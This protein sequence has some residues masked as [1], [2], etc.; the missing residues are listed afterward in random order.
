MKLKKYLIEKKAE[1]T[2]DEFKD[3]FIKQLN[4]WDT[5]LSKLTKAYNSMK[6]PDKMDFYERKPEGGY[7]LKKGYQNMPEYKNFLYL[8]QA[9]ATFQ[10]NF[11]TWVYS[12]VLD[13]RYVEKETLGQD[14]V[15]KTA[16]SF[17][18]DLSIYSL[19]PDEYDYEIE[20]HIPAPW[21]LTPT[22][23]KKRIT[24]YQNRWRKFKEAFQFLVQYGAER[25]EKIAP[26][27]QIQISGV[28]ILIKN[29]KK[30]NDKDVKTFISVVKKVVP[31]IKK[32][33]MGKVLRDFSMELNFNV[34]TTQMYSKYGDLV[35]G[36]YNP[37]KDELYIFP[38]GIRDKM[39]DNTLIHEL[40]HRYW[41]K[42]IPPK[43]KQAWED[44]INAQMIKVEKEHIEKFFKEF[45]GE[46]G[47]PYRRE[48]E[49][50]I[51]KKISDP[52]LQVIFEYLAD[53]TPLFDAKGRDKKTVYKEW[54]IKRHVGQQV[55]LEM[56]SDYGRTNPI[57]AFA[58]AFKIWVGGSK[59]KLGEW[60]RAFF[61]EIV[62]TGGATIKEENL[63]EKYLG[64]GRGSYLDNKKMP[65]EGDTV[66]ALVGFDRK[67]V[68][69]TITK[70]S[71]IDQKGLSN[72]YLDLN[73]NGK[74]YHL[75]ISQIY[76]HK[77]K[78]M[79]KKDEYG[80]VTVWE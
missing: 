40:G 69:G 55:P 46:Y 22:E 17:I 77:P 66:F 39:D 41:Y 4:Q 36:G 48:F 23:K 13:N 29:K 7:V 70:I 32:A 12:K 42:Y 35:G 59:G 33:G 30:E 61:K 34:A 38:L 20:K 49:N 78:Q 26:D 25:L 71:N 73:V 27:E 72:T 58:E 62:R 68:K 37:S 24:I 47:F 57:E 75:D 16:W 14:D 67:V 74:N 28:N 9:F 11:E 31:V 1:M 10:K 6:R 52:T 8:K 15:R 44:K 64:E 63:I 60:T 18:V 21:S 50:E 43:A 51:K 3:Y 53:N 80:E 56:I 65:K 79:K 5:D 45:W 19:F 2:G 54:M 76:D